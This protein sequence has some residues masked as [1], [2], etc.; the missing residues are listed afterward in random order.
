M[1]QDELTRGQNSKGLMKQGPVEKGQNG[2]K[3]KGLIYKPIL[4][5]YIL[6]LQWMFYITP[7]VLK[8]QH[9]ASIS[10]RWRSQNFKHTKLNHRK[11]TRIIKAFLRSSSPGAWPDFS[12]L[13]GWGLTG[14]QNSG[15][16]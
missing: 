5:Y 3:G 8:L 12:K 2:Q 9:F 14:I 10:L 13:G 16:K 15:Y 7:T 11:I 1:K 4:K 6:R